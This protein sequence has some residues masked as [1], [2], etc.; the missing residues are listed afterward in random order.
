MARYQAI[1]TMPFQSGNPRDVTVN[2]W[3][4]ESNSGSPV[5]AEWLDIGAALAAFYSELEGWYSEVVSGEAQIA[6]YD[7]DA[8][9]PRTPLFEN[10]SYFDLGGGDPL[11]EEV[12]VCVSFRGVFVSGSPKGRRR[13]R[14]YLGPLQ[15][16]V[17]IYDSVTA[18]TGVSSA[19]QTVCSDAVQAL[20][21]GLDGTGVLHSVWS[22]AD[23]ELYNVVEYWMDNAFD[24]QR[25]RG[26]DAWVP[27][28]ILPV[29]DE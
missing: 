27:K 9:P 1:L 14:I 16:N 11:P 19:F 10:T 3:A 28:I 20:Q 8:E 21:D 7:I 17:V 24:T 25:R 5:E 2:T 12:A 23:D 15:S 29:P 22:R 6:I 18:K 4:F 13:G 26:M